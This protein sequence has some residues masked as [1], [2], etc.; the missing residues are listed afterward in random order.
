MDTYYLDLARVYGSLN[1]MDSAI[2]A[3]KQATSINP[4]SHQNWATL[5]YW[6]LQKTL[7]SDSASNY[8]YAYTLCLDPKKSLMYLNNAFYSKILS[9]EKDDCSVLEITLKDFVI[10]KELFGFDENDIIKSFSL[11]AES[12]LS[13]DNSKQA[14]AYLSLALDKFPNNIA[15]KQNYDFLNSL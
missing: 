13:R 1:D 7:Y 6:Q 3:C 14:L 12:E 5:A 11:L 4:Y 15:L 8:Y 2:S 10:N 9:K